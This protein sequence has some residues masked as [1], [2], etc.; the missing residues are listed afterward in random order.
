LWTRVPAL[1]S[2]SFEGTRVRN[3]QF[4]VAHTVVF[5]EGGVIGRGSGD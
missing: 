2:A 1:L 3:S 5:I 4:I